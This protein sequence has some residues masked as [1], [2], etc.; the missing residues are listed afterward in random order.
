L[1]LE[2]LGAAQQTAA[3]VATLYLAALLPTVGVVAVLPIIMASL[4]VLEG[5]LE[6]QTLLNRGLLLAALE[7]H[8]LRHQ[9]KEIMVGTAQ[10]LEVDLLEEEAA[11][12][13]LEQMLP[14]LMLEMAVME[15]HPP[16]LVRLFIM[17]VE[18]AV[19]AMLLTLLV[20]EVLEVVGQGK[21]E[22]VLLLLLETQ[23]QAVA[24]VVAL[25]ILVRLAAP[26]L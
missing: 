22:I 18:V 7:T 6:M 19:L 13:R 8:L 2:G 14:V 24:V 5:V 20:L 21:L 25:I 26:V 16:F 10:L 4:V 3:A 17:L 12:M 1:A 9:V 23:T 11:L 15:L